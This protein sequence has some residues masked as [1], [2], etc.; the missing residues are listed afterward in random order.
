MENKARGIPRTNQRRKEE[1]IQRQTTTPHPPH[2][3]SIQRVLRNRLVLR[4][5]HPPR[6]PDLHA[7]AL[8]V[9]AHGPSRLLA[10]RLLDRDAQHLRELLQLLQRLARARPRGLVPVLEELER[11]ALD[12]VHALRKLGVFLHGGGT[13]DVG[14]VVAGVGR[15][16]GGCVEGGGGGA[17]KSGAEVEGALRG[18][19]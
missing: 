18:V 3:L 12:R 4:G 1:K 5:Q 13:I 2:P 7:G 8:H 6:V 10:L 15:A 17:R 11:V 19:A 9:R 16:C 14:G